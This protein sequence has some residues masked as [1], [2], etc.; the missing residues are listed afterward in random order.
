MSGLRPPAPGQGPTRPRPRPPLR[1]HLIRRR[2][3]GDPGAEPD[4][5]PSGPHRGQPRALPHRPATGTP[6]GGGQP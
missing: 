2:W 5:Q 3:P 1:R 4:E 6:S